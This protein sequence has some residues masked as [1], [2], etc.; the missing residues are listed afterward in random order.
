MLLIVF[1][2]LRHTLYERE[3]DFARYTC[4]YPREMLLEREIRKRWGV[5]RS[6]HRASRPSFKWSEQFSISHRSIRRDPHVILFFWLILLKC[7]KIYIVHEL[8]YSFYF[9]WKNINKTVKPV[10]KASGEN[11]NECRILGV[12]FSLIKIKVRGNFDETKTKRNFRYVFLRY[13]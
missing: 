8:F 5:T 4:S 7:N 1:F 11:A 12:F 2:Y 3:T 6:T 9:I 13:L 10:F